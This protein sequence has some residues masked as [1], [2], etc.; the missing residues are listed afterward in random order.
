MAETNDDPL[1]EMPIGNGDWE[2]KQGDSMSSIADQTG[3]FWPT[4]W[5]DPA[6]KKLKEKRADPET[7]YPGDKVKVP[8]LR[9]KQ[10][11]R[12]VDLIH[13]FKRKGVPIEIS[14]R[15]SLPEEI[16]PAATP[17]Q[18]K[19]GKRTYQGKT[20]DDGCL[21]HWITPSAKKGTLTFHLD[22]PR[23][24]PKI[25]RTLEVGYLAPID[26]TSGVESRLFNLG[27]LSPTAETEDEDEDEILASALRAFQRANDLEET[28]EPDSETRDALKD[29]HGV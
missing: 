17:Y 28:D 11:K 14:F 8:D 24:P 29:A 4:I 25:T 20:D 16:S 5:N 18:L 13:S 2:V 10:E 9:E 15:L 1:D 6:N 22:D 23:L 7:L 19:V 21:T 27:F 26:T 12:A 3:H